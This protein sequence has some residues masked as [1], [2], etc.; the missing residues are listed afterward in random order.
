MKGR[1]QMEKKKKTSHQFFSFLS[2]LLL[3]SNHR[4]YLWLLWRINCL[5]SSGSSCTEHSTAS[6]L[7]SGNFWAHRPCL[8][9]LF[10]WS[11][12][13]DCFGS[14]IACLSGCWHSRLTDG[15]PHCTA[16]AK[17][18]VLPKKFTQACIWVPLYEKIYVHPWIRVAMR[19]RALKII[20]SPT[21]TSTTSWI[22]FSCENRGLFDNEIS[23]IIKFNTVQYFNTNKLL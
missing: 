7:P 5:G 13:K 22:L 18:P 21:S 16:G 9:L 17:A 1:Q 6:F 14:F 10:D 19:E 23:I 4:I 20:Q 11:K 12:A 3:I 2:C 15:L 8:C